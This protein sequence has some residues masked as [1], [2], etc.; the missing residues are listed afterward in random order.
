MSSVHS[1]HAAIEKLKKRLRALEK[2][3]VEGRKKLHHAIEKASAYACAAFDVERKFIK[4][5]QKK[6]K[7]IKAAVARMDGKSVMKLINEITS[8][9]CQSKSKPAAKKVRK[10]K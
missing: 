4:E 1:H 8:K 6:S 2:K 3:E 9:V 7:D 10:K 5:V